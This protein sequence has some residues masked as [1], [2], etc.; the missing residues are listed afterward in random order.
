MLSNTNFNPLSFEQRTKGSAPIPVT[1]VSR[2]TEDGIISKVVPLSESENPYS[3]LKDSDFSLRSSL[4]NGVDMRLT[5]PL[6]SSNGVSSS[7]ARDIID[8]NFDAFLQHQ[9][10]PVSNPQPVTNNGQASQNS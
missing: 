4:R 7:S 10:Q 5:K 6:Y 1:I 2:E 9:Q 8:N 3:S